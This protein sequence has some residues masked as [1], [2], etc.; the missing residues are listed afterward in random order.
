MSQNLVKLSAKMFARKIG[1]RPQNTCVVD[2]FSATEI[3]PKWEAMQMQKKLKIACKPEHIEQ[4]KPKPSNQKHWKDCGEPKKQKIYTCAPDPEP[5]RRLRKESEK[6]K[7]C[8]HPLKPNKANSSICLVEKID[9]CSKCLMPGCR[10]T[11]KPVTCIQ[12]KDPTICK[13]IEAPVSS[14][15]ECMKRTFPPEERVS[16]NCSI[17]NVICGRPEKYA[18]K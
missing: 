3:D 18:N 6:S 5:K 14:F 1:I 4:E 2:R 7:Q 11:R 8:G 13:K 16:N 17:R 12:Y 9:T 10:P 15:H